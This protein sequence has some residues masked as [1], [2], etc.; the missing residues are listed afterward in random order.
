[1]VNFFEDKTRQ[2]R[3]ISITFAVIAI[4]LVPKLASSVV[5]KT[6]S[7][8][9]VINQY[10]NLENFKCRVLRYNDSASYIISY[11]NISCLTKLNMSVNLITPYSFSSCN[12]GKFMRTSCNITTNQCSYIQRSILDVEQ[13][14]QLIAISYDGIV[15]PGTGLNVAIPVL[16]VFLY[17]IGFLLLI[18]GAV[19]YEDIRSSNFILM[20]AGLHLSLANHMR[21]R[22]CEHG[23]CN[24][25]I[26]RSI[27]VDKIV[28][29]GSTDI[30]LTA[31]ATFLFKYSPYFALLPIVYTLS[32]TIGLSFYTKIVALTVIDLNMG[33]LAV[34]DLLLINFSNFIELIVRVLYYKK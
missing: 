25:V 32:I 34:F 14:I 23:I 18:V 6:P 22:F 8:P 2:H 1:M 30:I 10:D 31:L 19:L 26:V 29:L 15:C 21:M 4:G 20:L 24:S 3:I 27:S 13:S 16:V 5:Y 28:A 12:N 9:S 33:V 11:N 7:I 17:I